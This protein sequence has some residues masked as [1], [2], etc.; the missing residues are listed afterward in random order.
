M[1]SIILHCQFNHHTQ[2]V[3]PFKL[4]HQGGN[5]LIV[6]YEQFRLLKFSPQFAFPVDPGLCIRLNYYQALALLWAASTFGHYASQPNQQFW[7]L[8]LEQNTTSSSGYLRWSREL[9]YILSNTFFHRYFSSERQKVICSLYNFRNKN[10]SE[11]ET[12]VYCGY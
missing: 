9:T 2:P 10:N 5:R 12:V 7:V 3:S 4:N 1:F 6:R 11:L 8:S